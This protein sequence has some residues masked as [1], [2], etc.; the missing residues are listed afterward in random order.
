M[1][2]LVMIAPCVDYIIGQDNTL[3][4]IRMIDQIVVDASEEID[5]S[6]EA[7]SAPFHVITSWVKESGDN[8]YM[9][10]QRARVIT[11]SGTTSIDRIARFRFGD[12]ATGHYTAAKVTGFPV[13]EEGVYQIEIS[14][15]RVDDT[16]EWTYCNAHPFRVTHRISREIIAPPL[17][18]SPSASP[19]PS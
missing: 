5:A 11:P 6:M 3:S 13:H 10:E 4:I 9:F 7:V 2:R 12:K 14:L 8:G 15:R 18:S 16:Q 17:D 19:P 1:A